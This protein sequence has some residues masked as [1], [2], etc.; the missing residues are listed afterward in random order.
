[1]K[2]GF[3]NRKVIRP[4]LELLR[5]GATPEKL[6]LSVALGFVFGLLP[7]I[8]WNTAMCAIV[9]F[10][11]KL[12]LPAIQLVNYSLYPLQLALLLPF[13]RLGERVFRAPHLPVSIPQIYAM[14]HSDLW[15]AVRLLWSTT[16][17]AV[18]VWALLAPLVSASIYFAL[19]PAFRRVVQRHRASLATDHAQAHE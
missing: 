19:V 11:W 16:W 4:L 1:M 13:F 18:A 15:G 2:L 12:N 9:A 14:V 3:L 7:A 6:A 8:G 17:H 5:Q 10:M